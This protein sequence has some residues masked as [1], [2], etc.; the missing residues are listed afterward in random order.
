MSDRTI[1][2]LF[3]TIM[4][5]ICI[6]G[7]YLKVIPTDVSVP[8]ITFILGHGFGSM[9]NSSS[10]NSNSNTNVPIITQPIDTTRGI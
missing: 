5:V 3:Y 1:S 10:G 9:P 8:A 4:L 6:V 2:L 7:S